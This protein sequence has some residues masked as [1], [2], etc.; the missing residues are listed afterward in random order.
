MSVPALQQHFSTDDIQKVII[1]WNILSRALEVNS[2]R[3][4]SRQVTSPAAGVYTSTHIPRLRLAPRFNV[5]S[6]QKAGANPI[7]VFPSM[8]GDACNMRANGLDIED[9]VVCLLLLRA[10]PNEYGVI[11]WMFQ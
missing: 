7:P 10:L 5:C 1:V 11:R 2:N 8:I 9:E 3:D 6:F 4:T